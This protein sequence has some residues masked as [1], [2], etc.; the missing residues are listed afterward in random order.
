MVVVKTIQKTL[1]ENDSNEFR[2]TYTEPLL[3]ASTDEYRAELESKFRQSI[4]LFPELNPKTVK[5]GLRRTCVAS[6]NTYQFECNQGL[7]SFGI[8][9]VEPITF[10]TIGHELTH[11][12]QVISDIPSGEKQCDVWTIARNELFLD[13]P[14]RYIDIP[15]V[16]RKNWILHK[17]E[18]RKLTIEAKEIRNSKKQYIYWLEGKICFI[19][20]I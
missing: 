4:L 19:N 13:K 20:D 1:A 10:Y 6:A 8:N 14:P 7:M 11:F 5:F 18:I 17:D 15:P 16:V 3:K 12:L 9:P 2:I